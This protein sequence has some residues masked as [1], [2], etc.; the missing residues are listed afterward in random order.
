MLTDRLLFYSTSFLLECTVTSTRASQWSISLA[1]LLIHGSCPWSNHAQSSIATL[2]STPQAHLIVCEISCTKRNSWTWTLQ[3]Q[4]G[5]FT[6]WSGSFRAKNFNRTRRCFFLKKWTRPNRKP[7]QT[8]P[9]RL[10]HGQFFWI[11]NQK[12]WAQNNK[13]FL[14]M[15]KPLEFSFS[16]SGWIKLRVLKLVKIN[17]DTNPK[18]PKNIKKIQVKRQENNK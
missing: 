14:G 7:V 17:H 1:F 15:G 2:Y 8:E 10:C 9:V 11:K 4:L 16:Q 5:V 6:L 18:N 3:Y 12:T 13:W